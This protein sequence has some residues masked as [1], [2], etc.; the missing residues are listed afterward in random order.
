M[1]GIGSN[2][3]VGGGGSNVTVLL[4]TEGGRRLK[5]GWETLAY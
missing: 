4:S 1:V 2:V 3:Y 5:H